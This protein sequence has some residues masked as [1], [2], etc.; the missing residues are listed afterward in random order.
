MRLEVERT[1]RTS[2]AYP[3][4]SETPKPLGVRESKQFRVPI[5]AGGVDV[6][7]FKRQFANFGGRIDVIQV[8]TLVGRGGW[9]SWRGFQS[10]LGAE[11]THASAT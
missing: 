4:R 7:R 2:I 11:A 8:Q 9:T 6:R 10:S 5:L 3:R 1:L